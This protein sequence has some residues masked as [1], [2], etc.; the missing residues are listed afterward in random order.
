MRITNQTVQR[1]AQNAQIKNQQRLEQAF[2]RLASGSRINS[3]ADDAAGLAISSRMTSQIRGYDQAIRNANDG[4]S[5]AQ[6]AESALGG[7]TEALQRMRELT[8]QAGNG[9]LNDQDRRAIQAEMDQLSEQIGQLGQ[10]E[11]NGQR[12]L[13]GEGGGAFQV[14]ANPNETIA[15]PRLYSQP[16]SLGTAPVTTSGEIDPSGLQ[17]G[18][19]SI[20]GVDIR[21]TQAADDTLS[22]T[23]NDASA[24]AVAAAIN[25]VAAETGVTATVEAAIVEGGAAI[26]GGALGATDSLSINGVAIAG[27][28]N[29]D[30]AGG[31]LVDAINAAA[32]Q[33]GV[34][35]SLTEQGRLSLTATDGRNIAVE[36]TGAAGAVTGLSAGVTTGRVALRGE[37]QF[38]L[39]GTDPTQAGFEAGMV[40]RAPERAISRVDV[41]R[42]EGV[43]PAL[44]SIDR[45]L[46][47]VTRDRARLGAIQNRFGYT[48]DNLTAT[49][50]NLSAARSRITDTDFAEEISRML[51]AQIKQQ[52]EIS[53]MSQANASN[54]SAMRLLGGA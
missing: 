5:Y 13:A 24:I 37:D 52:A 19:L 49:S 46:G 28:F 29:A 51:Q 4:I 32:E 54:Q 2:A 36:L 27:E 8:I 18:E 22:T 11:F 53:V 40:G 21:A 45:A 41:R 3:A 34:T 42:Q 14:G 23:Q 25:D 33:T 44:E 20:N 38:T 17:A 26:G 12:V 35:A 39:G 48:I 15:M 43:N 7:Q 47:E 31:G 16:E 6:T 1:R 30:D 9:I 50:E 10:T